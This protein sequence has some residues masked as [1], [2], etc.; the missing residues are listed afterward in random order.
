MYGRCNPQISSEGLIIMFATDLPAPKNPRYNSLDFWRGIACL[1][2]IISH[3]TFYIPKGNYSVLL[4]VTIY[5]CRLSW[6]GV[7][8]FFVISGYCISAA[9]DSARRRPLS[10]IS[11]F[12]RRFRRIYPPFWVCIFATVFFVFFVDHFS[13]YNIFSDN[14]HPIANPSS[15]DLQQWIGNLTLTE[16]WRYNVTPSSLQFF[17]GHAWTLCY[18]EQFY[19]VM[20]LLLFFFPRR[21][22]YAAAITTFFCFAAR[23]LLPRLNIPV[24]G[25]FFDGQWS[26]FAAG[27][28]VYYYLNYKKS[29]EFFV[30]ISIFS[31]GLLYSLRSPALL[32][33][34]PGQAGTD[35]PTCFALLFAILL[36]LLHRYDAT[37]ANYRPFR[38]IIFCGTMCYSLYL[39][40]WPVTKFI[41]HLSFILG[42]NSAVSI[43][44]L[45]VPCC[46]ASSIAVGWFFHLHV[47]RRFLNSP[48][49]AN[50]GL[51]DTR[52]DSS[53]ALVSKQ[54]SSL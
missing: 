6:I 43:L 23:H 50:K 13:T 16:K 11:Y 24:S 38:P 26:M 44:A 41:S 14:I 22:F 48:L 33:T 27:I 46:I 32:S 42:V 45:T 7:P 40:H 29:K 18:E 3:A 35:I 4:S 20:G 52:L 53:R 34:L 54:N 51:Q 9:V 21:I 30:P 2:V 36:L 5:F 28:L 10:I 12:K 25:F 15:L 8:L 1:L 37:I 31:L 47:E 39:I 17:M 49:P 19:V